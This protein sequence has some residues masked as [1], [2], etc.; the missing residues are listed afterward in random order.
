MLRRIQRKSDVALKAEGDALRY[1]SVTYVL[2]KGFQLCI[3]RN[4]YDIAS[5]G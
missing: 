1:A 2:R 4:R 3:V 5:G